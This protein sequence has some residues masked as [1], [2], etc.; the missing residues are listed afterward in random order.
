MPLWAP[1]GPG[2]FVYESSSL[3]PQPS[4]RTHLQ[5]SPRSVGGVNPASLWLA[6]LPFFPIS[7]ASA[8]D[9]GEEPFLFPDL[10]NLLG[11]ILFSGNG[12][13]RVV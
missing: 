5:G 8:V 2:A 11:I 1:R 7:P 9:A 6:P 12:K 4:P 13:L 10:L 3:L